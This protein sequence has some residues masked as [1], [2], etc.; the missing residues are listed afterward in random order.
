MTWFKSE[1][2]ESMQSGPETNPPSKR[3]FWQSLW[4]GVFQREAISGTPTTPPPYWQSI[5]Y[6]KIGAAATSV[7]T[8]QALF[9]PWDT[10]VKNALHS[11]ERKAA[12]IAELRSQ[13][14]MSAIGRSYQGL[15][16]AYKKKGLQRGQKWF[17]Q[18]AVNEWLKK[19]YGSDFNTMFGTHAQT[20]RAGVAGGITG[21]LEPFFV[22]YF[23][24]KQVRKQLLQKGQI[25]PPLSVRDGY[26]ATIFTGIARNLPGSIGLFGGSEYFNFLLNNQDKSNPYLNFA[27]KVGGAFTSSLVSQPGDVIKTKMQQEFISAREA[28]AKTTFKEMLTNGLGPRLA[29]N[30]VKVAFGFFVYEQMVKHIESFLNGTTDMP[31]CQAAIQ[32][33][34]TE[35][36]QA[37]PKIEEDLKSELEA[38]GN[39]G[40]SEERSAY[41]LAKIQEELED[42][43]MTSKEEPP[44]TT[45]SYLS[46]WE[47]SQILAREELGDLSFE[48]EKKD[49]YK[50]SNTPGSK[51]C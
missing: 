33:T 3:N 21:L 31:T 22:Q 7:A 48:Y 5:P 34:Q 14:F 12:F 16:D 23:D 50:P 51:L 1:W 27:A 36:N 11:P 44:A 8:E 10:F 43:S 46:T 37:W 38:L 18:D 26:R 41:Q 25:L 47:L 19:H 20:A 30:S 9:Y 6:A 24:T 2:K 17:F 15:L 49:T 39:T 35:L 13:S 29:L 42:L 28:F 4:A 40:T 45:R 32:K